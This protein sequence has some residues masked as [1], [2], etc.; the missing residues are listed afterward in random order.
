[1]RK[2]GKSGFGL[3]EIVIASVL[4]SVLGIGAMRMIE[5]LTK[6][7]KLN[8]AGAEIASIKMQI[9]TLLSSS[10]TCPVGFQDLSGNRAKFD[11]SNLTTP[12]AN[13]LAQLKI[14]SLTLAKK[15]E[16]NGI[17]FV[18]SIQLTELD[19]TLRSNT[20]VS[21]IA[22]R[23]FVASLDLSL[24]LGHSADASG[25]TRQIRLPI[26]IT[27]N[28]T[29]GSEKNQILACSV[30]GATLVGGK[31]ADMWS[32]SRTSYG[33]TVGW[34]TIPGLSITFTL[35]RP[36]KITVSASGQQRIYKSTCLVSYRTVVNGIGL[37]NPTYG[38]RIQRQS[39]E[40]MG[41]AFNYG[42]SLDA[43]VHTISIQS[44]QPQGLGCMVCAEWNSSLPEY[45]ACDLTIQAFYQ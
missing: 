41:W 9:Q 13:T 32:A 39:G 28:N 35:P 24:V 19:P 17:F 15:G 43:G 26:L 10:E 29:T 7:G 4:L 22:A 8:G 18:S 21:S 25:F 36:A 31:T 40:H 5:G 44:A 20:V 27:T 23:T 30:N 14:G 12:L 6:A 2:I 11:P 38:Q 37:G 42:Q 3:L 16:K 33:N 45:T 1:M 34:Q